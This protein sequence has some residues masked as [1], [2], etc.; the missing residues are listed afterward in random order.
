MIDSSDVD[1][2]KIHKALAVTFK[3]LRRMYTT[4]PTSWQSPSRSLGYQ[5]F[6]SPVLCEQYPEVGLA[7]SWLMLRLGE[8]SPLLSTATSLTHPK[9]SVSVLLTALRFPSPSPSHMLH[10]HPCPLLVEGH[11]NLTVDLCCCAPKY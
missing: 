9:I 4:S 7:A 1:T 10:P 5:V 6:A 11:F 3:S 2:P 8:F